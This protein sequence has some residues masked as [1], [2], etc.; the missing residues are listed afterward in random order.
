MVFQ[1]FSKKASRSRTELR[2]GLVSLDAARGQ[3]MARHIANLDNVAMS[4]ISSAS[5]TR[6]KPPQNVN[7]LVYDLDPTSE[8]SLADFD[9]FMK[10]RPA[11]VPVVV[12]S[13]AVD[14]ELV[15]WFLRLRVADW[16]KTPLTKGELISAAARVLS[17][18]SAANQGLRCVTFIG[19]RGGVGATT[20]AV[21]A[22]LIL[23]QNAA[24][25]STMLVDL[26]LAGGSCSD[27]LDMAAGWQVDELADDPSRLDDRMLDGMAPQHGSGLT[28]LSAHRRFLTSSEIP[29]DVVTRM[30]DAASRRFG[31]LVIDLPRHWH[32]WS[33]GVLGGSTDVF[34]VTDP[35]VPGLKAASRL[36]GELA[37]ELGS[38]VVPQIIVN[39]FGHSLF[40][41]GLSVSELKR[42]LG[43]AFAG[44]V[45][46]EEKL[47]REAID[48]GV[49]LTDV[50]SNTRVLRDLKAILEA[51]ASSLNG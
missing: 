7:V 30:L 17:Q 39:K 2:A 8:A 40:G 5:V 42:H 24:V 4:A 20:L 10:A 50:K 27:Y 35:T 12:L 13:P 19:A 3:Q 36:Q 38:E 41:T 48:R 51:S 16:V 1:I 21:H 15:R 31:N 47:V 34:V 33:D 28:V 45:A 29:D 44:T 11:D 9:R 49:P 46:D 43:A 25:Q 37:T 22:A 32:S 6:E 18:N 26:D 23:N 14:D